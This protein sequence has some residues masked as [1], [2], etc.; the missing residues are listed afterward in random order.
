MKKHRPAC[1]LGL[2]ALLTAA[3]ARNPSSALRSTNAK[4]EPPVLAA[5]SAPNV[6][7][8][9][10]VEPKALPK[11]QFAAPPAGV[12]TPLAGSPNPDQLSAA[13]LDV[14]TCDT[15]KE[16]VYRRAAP[17]IAKMREEVDERYEQ[18]RA[19]QPDCWEEYRRNEE[20]WRSLKNGEAFGY[21]GLGLSGI[22]EGGGGRGEGIG[23]AQIGS[24]GQ[25]FGAGHGRLAGS[26]AARGA[27]RYSRTNNQV[28]NVD[29]ADLVKTDGRYLYLSLNGAL[30]IVEAMKPRVL[31]V[32]KLPGRVRDLFV[33]GDRAVVYSSIGGN[34]SKP[35]RYGYDCSF[36]GDGSATHISVLDVSDRSAPKR[37]RE[38]ELSGSLLASRRI[39]NS[40]HSVVTQGD[41]DAPPYDVWMDDLP[42]CGVRDAAV[43]ARV[44]RLKQRNEA[45]IRTY[46]ASWAPT[47]RERGVE[48]KLCEH[49]WKSK[50]ED[51]DAFTS[52]VS[53]DLTNDAEQA[54]TTTLRSRPGA[55]FASADALYVSV[56]HDKPLHGRA[57]YRPFGRSVNEIS[58]VHKFSLGARPSDTRY[59]GSGVVPGHVLN[60][61]AMDQWYGYLRVATSRGRVPD[62][63]VESQ[64][65][66]LA[67]DQS[68]SLVRVG[69][70]EHMAPGE[71]IRA[72]RF[73]GD[74]GY[75]VTFKKTD[76]LF[77]L[78]LLNPAQP[79]VLGA[80][81][82]PGFSTYLQRID[83]DHLI[84]IGFDADDHG[85]FAYYDGLLLQLFDVRTPTDPKLLFR[86]KI[87]TRG[88]ASEAA[89]DHLAFNYF[90]ERGLLAIPATICD[91]G[92]DGRSGDKLSFSGLLVYNV[93]TR[94]GFKRLGGVNHG[95]SGANCAAWWSR[96]ESV[97]KRSVFLDDL[98]YSVA[99]NRVKAQRLA[100][101]GTDLADL[102][103]TY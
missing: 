96:S 86:E 79:R 77:V 75:V 70:V 64:I 99:S 41:V 100:A 20:Y 91:G 45:A 65:S 12:L 50:I 56:A 3:C 18:Y 81:K 89:T 88:S 21:G 98:V 52:L 1:V 87:G 85:S 59:V 46:V 51:G 8:E 67:Q 72:V 97:V 49:V 23:L 43:R 62:P 37:V 29:E 93:D 5:K 58:E 54:F 4:L 76:P 32:T 17:L 22:G 11:A 95:V 83:P 66:I 73:D 48:R 35:C 27:K 28:A 80:L 102:D 90:G 38:I 15:S 25:G 34:R 71:D 44:A 47:I 63:K 68:G 39:G 10:A 14:G 26:H 36:S 92:G 94:A 101:L 60:Q 40:V 84:S 69:A 31:S 42:E 7:T 78:D 30:R 57:A 53:F 9:A 16:A 55:V 19:A 33:E 74:R 6:K 61:F 24:I 103:M 2:V 82:I 13:R